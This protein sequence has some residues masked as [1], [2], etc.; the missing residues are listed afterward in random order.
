MEITPNRDPFWQLLAHW[1][2]GSA[3][4]VIRLGLGTVLFLAA[5]ALVVLAVKV[6]WFFIRLVLQAVGG[7]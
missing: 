3:G 1:A 2:A 5:L 4:F 6:L 7:F